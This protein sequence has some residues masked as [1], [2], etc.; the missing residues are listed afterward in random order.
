MPWRKLR[1]FALVAT[2]VVFLIPPSDAASTSKDPA[3]R[4]LDLFLHMPASA[5]PGGAL[6]LQIQVFGYP[7]VTSLAPL[8]GAVVEAVWDPESLGPGLSKAPPPVRATSD[9]TGRL[10]LDLPVPPGPPQTLSLLV[11]VRHG[12]H[13][14][15]RTYEISRGATLRVALHVPELRVVPG[16]ETSAWVTVTNEVTGEP[17]PDTPV[18]VGLTEGG[19]RRFSTT[20]RTDAAGTAQ[21]RLPIPFT[22]EP[23]LTWSLFA[24]PLGDAAYGVE[25]SVTLTQRE[26]TPAT[27]T[28]EAY[29]VESQVLA[30]DRAL[31]R[32]RLRDA[33]DRPLAN[34]P[35]RYWVGPK[36]VEPPDER[37][38]WE[39]ASI[40][41][42]TDFA[43]EIEGYFDAPTTVVAGIGT[44]LTM[45]AR[46]TAD[47]HELSATSVVAVEA[48]AISLE[49]LPEAGVLV[50]GVS[51]RLLLRVRDRRNK[52]ISAEF[53]L[54]G[55]GLDARVKTDAYGEAEVTWD[56][57]QE[58]GA[59]RNVGPCAGGVAAAVVVRW[60]G[61][62]AALAG[63]DDPF[64]PCVAV[65][66]DA[67][68]L[69]VPSAPLVRA[70]KAAEIA[71]VSTAA[72]GKKGTGPWSV[73]MA[74]ERGAL[75]T[76]TWLP[77]DGRGSVPIPKGAFGP[78]DVGAASPVLGKPARTVGGSILVV[79][80]VLPR[81][82]A[83]V[84]GGRAVPGGSVEID[85]ALADEHGTGLAG[86]VAAMIID[87]RGGGHVEGLRYLDTRSNLCDD[88]GV[89][90]AR[91][92]RMLEGDPALMSVLRAE[93][94]GRSRVLLGPQNDPGGALAPTLRDGFAAVVRSLEGAVFEA[95]SSPER[96]R[97][98][99]RAGPNGSM[100]WNPE[101]MTLVTAAMSEPPLT[102]GGEPLALS[103]LFTI[104][105][106]VTFDNV[107]HRITRVKVFRV[108]NEVR[109]FRRERM[110]DPDEPALTDPNAMLRRIVREGRLTDENLLDPWGGTIQ[111]TKRRGP[112]IP[113]VTVARNLELCSPGPDRR[114]NTGDDVC[115]PFA[116]VLRSGTPYAVAVQEDRIVDARFDMEVADATVDAWRMLF[117]E[118]TGTELGGA[119]GLGL[120]GFGSGGGGRGEG[121]G[122]GGIGTRGSGGISRGK[123]A[124]LPPVR[125]DERGHVRLTVPLGDA[126]TTWRVAIVGAPDRARP[127]VTNVDVA[128]SLPLSVRVELGARW[129]EK[130]E[131]E[132]PL[133]V[134]NRSEK[135]IEADVSLGVFGAAKLV[136]PKQASQRVKVS[137]G[138][139]ARVTARVRA[140]TSGTAWLDVEA[141]AAGLP[142]DRLHHEW[143]VISA[144][145]VVTVGASSWVADEGQ[146]S[147]QIPPGSAQ[148]VGKPW[149]VLERGQRALFAAALEAMEPDLLGSPAAL[150]DAVEVGGRIERWAVAEGGEASTLV[151]QARDVRRRA[152]GRLSAYASSASQVPTTALSAARVRP[153]LSAID[154]GIFR[155]ESTCPPQGPTLEV[156]LEGLDAEPAPVSGVVLACWEAFVS[157]TLARV[158]ESENPLAYARAVLALAERPHRR[159]QALT[160]GARLAEL[161]RVDAAGYVALDGVDSVLRAPRAVV[162][163]A[164]LR[165]SVMG[166][167]SPASPA[168][169]FAWL[170]VQRDSFG[171][172]GGSL[173]T[174]SAVR[175]LFA[176]SPAAPSSE[177]PISVVVTADGFEQSVA[178]GPSAKVVLP[179]ASGAEDVRIEAK[180]AGVVARLERVV[181]RPW[182]R[183][184]ADEGSPVHL[185]SEWPKAPIAGRV[186]PL[187]LRLRHDLGRPAT[188]DV[189]IP[190]PPGVHLA[191]PVGEA[192]EVFGVLAVRARLDQS[193]LPTV[194]DVP[195]R[196]DLAGA[197]TVPEGRARVAFEDHRMSI[198][199]ARP[200]TVR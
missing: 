59:L 163:A 50:P 60:Q 136:D 30:G 176:F 9:A 187:R 140:T 198:A 114:I 79:P 87:A 149:L 7:T 78:W 52:G 89:D 169:L 28:L 44:T 112:I 167:K 3:A 175:A 99:R 86:T 173:A 150:A 130:D 154:E 17:E 185:D 11:G 106:Q 189:R 123:G 194:I 115:D 162:Y 6:P 116:R 25:S 85:V 137:A 184:P 179:I 47:G 94:A 92:D 93:L 81:L 22:E 2:M 43:G 147:V 110:L 117:E 142:S 145:E 146:L 152:L 107:A 160:L 102:P 192:R 182:S 100:T 58:V 83:K 113:F 143:D 72:G 132:V 84:V 38:A 199:P 168:A 177:G 98:V 120:S 97:D 56:A 196:F 157:D 48:R 161:T 144:G 32:V 134:R 16:G 62:V 191:A 5:P 68:T 148:R 51:Q 124:F 66:R 96:L 26:E 23:S 13:K 101:L 186:H 180:G 151:E 88:V 197:V 34:V 69:L 159:A 21:T 64:E 108:L 127:A 19:V 65:D 55:D 63:R 118:L 20:L 158:R 45:V 104:D 10:H 29:W 164:L 82:D 111:F 1:L 181:I 46:A 105:P 121:I 35:V 165:A 77:A 39:Q 133:L 71:L 170:V 91:C 49:L 141:K 15:T 135:P 73:L 138:G 18:D 80:A 61:E 174:R 190:L 166:V 109:S 129:V 119:G 125:T 67:T 12:D 75:S 156:G 200:L 178:V 153:W 70:G 193:A 37:V 183:V 171:G 8:E 128:A 41:K 4:G 57:P 195:L 14:R 122:L 131:L 95:S 31:F 188:I 172:Y 103:D 139:V 126:E 24:R 155:S 76:S 27:P 74:A 36:G 40:L 54:Q 42:N 33:S 53:T 90:T